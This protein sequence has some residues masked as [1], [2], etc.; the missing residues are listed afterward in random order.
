MIIIDRDRVVVVVSVEFQEQGE[1]KKLT[2][3]G[4]LP[5]TGGE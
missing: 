5:F 2:A 4:D 1:R 3:D